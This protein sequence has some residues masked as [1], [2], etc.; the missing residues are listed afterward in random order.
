MVRKH[1]G[2]MV[3]EA[4]KRRQFSRADVE[5]GKQTMTRAIDIDRTVVSCRRITR[6]I[7][8]VEL[9]DCTC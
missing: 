4:A 9:V 1:L 7:L 8:K 5:T 6:G 3:W 2:D